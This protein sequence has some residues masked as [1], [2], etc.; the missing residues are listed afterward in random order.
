MFVSHRHQFVFLRTKKTAGTSIEVYLEQVLLPTEKQT[1]DDKRHL[2]YMSNDYLVGRRQTNNREFYDHMPHQQLARK[3]GKAWQR[4]FKFCG[5]RNPWDKAVSRY[6][7]ELVYDPKMKK[8]QPQPDAT[9][10]QIRSLFSSFV[11][12][13]PWVLTD[14]QRIYF[15]GDDLVVDRVI[16][17]EHLHED[18]AKICRRFDIPWKPE[19]LGTYKSQSRKHRDIDY[20]EYYDDYLRDF[21]RDKNKLEIEH[22]GYTF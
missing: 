3:L 19:L 8:Y 5:V 10:D 6:W 12:E 9:M 4:Y 20:H 18:F 11:L 13:C 16:R 2:Q 15:N 14:D 17:Y 7:W 21:V 22:F 1:L